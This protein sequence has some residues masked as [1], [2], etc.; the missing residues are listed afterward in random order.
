[1]EGISSLDC[2]YSVRVAL[3]QTRLL[4]KDVSVRAISLGPRSGCVFLP[5]SFSRFTEGNVRNC[6]EGVLC[7]L[8]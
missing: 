3:R 1:M 4:G 2:L 5:P 8:S 6:T 7:E